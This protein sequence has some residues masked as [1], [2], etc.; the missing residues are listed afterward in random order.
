MLSSRNISNEL[1][2]SLSPCKNNS[3]GKRNVLDTRKM[4]CPVAMHLHATRDHFALMLQFT[5]NSWAT[6]VSWIYLIGKLRIDSV[7]MLIS[8]RVI[9]LEGKV[10]AT[11]LEKKNSD[12]K[13][14]TEYR[15]RS[16]P[17]QLKCI[18]EDPNILSPRLES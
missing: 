2:T 4:H 16:Y 8:I 14:S 9:T 11:L 18:N 10:H 17:S 5:L 1:E 12:K 15:S 6:A 3:W 7:A 13:T